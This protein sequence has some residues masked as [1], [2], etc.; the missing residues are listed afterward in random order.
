MGRNAT[1][2][3]HASSAILKFCTVGPINLPSVLR[4]ATQ[5]PFSMQ[6]A[7]FADPLCIPEMD[8]SLLHMIQD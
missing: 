2:H 4:D 5:E 3:K 7:F 8:V 1:G 6:S